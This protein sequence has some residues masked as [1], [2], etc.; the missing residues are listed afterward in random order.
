MQSFT[1]TVETVVGD[2]CID[3][4]PN[5]PFNNWAVMHSKGAVYLNSI[6]DAL[7]WIEFHSSLVLEVQAV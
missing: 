4:K 6:Q 1:A 5:K 2:Y 7:D 3:Y